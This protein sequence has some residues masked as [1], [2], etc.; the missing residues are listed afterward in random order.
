M[1]TRIVI[2]V[3]AG[4]AGC[5]QPQPVVDNTPENPTAVFETVVSSTGIVGMFPFETTEK[6]YVRANM[7]RDEHAS[8]GTGRFTGFLMTRLMG[9]GDAAIARVDRK[10]SWM[11]NH[12]RKEYLECPL[13]G[14]AMPGGAEAPKP[15]AQ[16]EEPRQQAEEGCVMR[17]ASSKFDV[18]PTGQ[19]RE[20]NGF[21]TE[22]YQAA[23]VVRMQDSAKRTTTST[24]K[25]DVWTTPVNAQIRQALDTEAAFGRTLAAS[26]PR[27][28]PAAGKPAGERQVMMPPEVLAMMTG[29][30]TS[31]S[32][33]DRAALT[34]GVRELDKIKGHPISTKIEWLLDGNAC[35]A[36]DEQQPQQQTGAAGMLSGV[37]GRLLAKKEESGPKPLLSF[38]VEVKQLGVQPVRDS[39]FSVP[40]SYKL[41]KQP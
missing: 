8:R 4:V 12:G 32:P 36:K 24:V 3:A 29:Y 9:P 37:A 27:A 22:Q 38:T 14:C 23:W 35:G 11:L 10:L 1:R 34:R 31:L 15:Q 25:F 13:Q 39:V 7:R 20:L 40:A 16:R 5:A 21:N 26:A 2:A 19:K 41:A 28:A 17:V 33:A 18:T 30:L 6:H